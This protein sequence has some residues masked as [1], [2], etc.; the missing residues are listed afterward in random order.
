[1]TLAIDATTAEVAAKLSLSV[2]GS[3]LV[4]RG[5]RVEDPDELPS[6]IDVESVDV[7]ADESVRV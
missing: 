5:L 2:V 3:A 7:E 4:H 1:V 6:V